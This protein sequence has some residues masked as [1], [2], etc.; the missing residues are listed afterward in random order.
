MTT[1]ALLEQAPFDSDV[2]FIDEMG[3]LLA[4]CLV[5]DATPAAASALLNRPPDPLRPELLRD[6][7]TL[8]FL[9]VE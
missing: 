6:C 9:T 1:G 7:K 5:V 4:P 8:R 3:A 2:A